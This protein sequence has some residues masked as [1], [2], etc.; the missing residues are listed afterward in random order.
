MLAYLFFLFKIEFCFAAEKEFCWEKH[1][2]PGLVYLKFSQDPVQRELLLM[3][4]RLVRQRERERERV[5]EKR[6][7]GG[8][9][10]YTIAGYFWGSNAL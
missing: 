9:G 2:N 5:Y 10:R 3:D 6:E 8:E 4:V 7:G 1:V